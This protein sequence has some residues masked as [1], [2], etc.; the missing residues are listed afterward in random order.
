MWR[1]AN[2]ISDPIDT[3]RLHLRPMQERDAAHVAR[4]MTPAVTRWLAS[5]PSPV[6]EAL[7][8]ERI[9][10]MRDVMLKGHAVCLAIERRADSTFMGYVIV[11]RAKD[12]AT[13][14]GLGYWLGEPYQRQGFMTEA[15]AAAVA[16]A[17]A[18]LGLRVIEAGAQPENEGSLAIMRALG[19]RPI[20]TRST[21]A[22]GRQR[23]E[24][25]EYFEVTRD[26]FE[27]RRHAAR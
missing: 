22:A 10:Q 7:A 24:V 9:A 5:W 3:A 19:M 23:E 26:Q 16:A 17:F 2:S 15:A 11:F 13:R 12:D 1:A 20:G 21:W 8:R 6:T 25:C 18:R 14:G 27:G 4:L